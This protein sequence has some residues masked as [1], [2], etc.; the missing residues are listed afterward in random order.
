MVAG[1][2]PRLTIRLTK[3]AIFPLFPPLHLPAKPLERGTVRTSASFEL[4]RVIRLYPQIL[5]MR[6]LP[7]SPPRPSPNL[8]VPPLVPASFTRRLSI[9][10]PP[11]DYEIY[12]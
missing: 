4:A 3:E 12:F 7:A 8:C 6:Q 9:F 10:L 1:P 2:W 5:T 11:C